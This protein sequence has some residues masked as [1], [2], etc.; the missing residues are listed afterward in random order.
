[1]T[2]RSGIA[3][4]K[5][6]GLRSGKAVAK[7]SGVVFDRITRKYIRVMDMLRTVALRIE[8]MVIKGRI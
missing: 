2:A 3:K 5:G 7:G 1:M 4:A 6:L 8:V